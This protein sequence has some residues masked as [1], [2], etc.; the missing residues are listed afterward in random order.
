MKWDYEH[1]LKLIELSKAGDACA[2]ETLIKENAPLVKSIVKRFLGRG[3]DYEDLFQIGSIGLLKAISGFD[4]SFNVRFS[5]YAVPMVTG[6]LKRFIRDNTM[7][8]MPRSLKELQQKIRYCRQSLTLKNG[9]EPRTEDIAKELNCSVEDIILALDSMN[10]CASL[11]EPVFDEAGTTQMDLLEDK[12][13]RPLIT[14]KLALRQCLHQLDDKE[15]KV[16]FL[17]YYKDFTQTRIAEIMG[18][19]QVQISRIESRTLEK[20]RRKL[21]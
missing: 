9:C 11:D 5:T 2:R 14:D 20:L 21:G 19:S 18:I 6:E 4:A 13:I 8:K 16:I 15:K 3:V 17:R 12:R 7:V 10:P 1:T